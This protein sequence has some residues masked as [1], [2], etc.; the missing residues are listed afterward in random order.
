MRCLLKLKVLPKIYVFQALNTCR[1]ARY[2]EWDGEIR[3]VNAMPQPA[4]YRKRA[5]ECMEIAQTVQVTSQ[6]T[7]LK[8]IAETW[9]RL[10]QDAEGADSVNGTKAVN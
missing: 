9:L 4:E 3:K 7:M 10:A 5:E 6:R 1:V 8:H 2:L